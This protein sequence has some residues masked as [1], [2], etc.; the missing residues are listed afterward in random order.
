MGGAPVQGGG[1]RHTGRDTLRGNRIIDTPGESKRATFGAEMP[2]KHRDPGT[3]C[4]KTQRSGANKWGKER[5]PQEERGQKCWGEGTVGQLVAGGQVDADGGRR[6]RGGWLAQIS[7]CP[8]D[9]AATGDTE[10]TMRGY[11]FRKRTRQGKHKLAQVRT[12]NWPHMEAWA[13]G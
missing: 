9:R 2:R 4:Q 1:R 10:G 12:A 3:S 6:V 5:E 11:Q 7:E 13:D 8:I